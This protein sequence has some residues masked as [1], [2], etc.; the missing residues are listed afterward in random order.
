MTQPRKTTD[1]QRAA[2]LILPTVGAVVRE[3]EE[4]AITAEAEAKARR[5]S[6]DTTRDFQELATKARGRVEGAYKVLK[7][8]RTAAEG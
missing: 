2:L 7:A 3:L 1:R 4:T 8:V 5:K 6:H